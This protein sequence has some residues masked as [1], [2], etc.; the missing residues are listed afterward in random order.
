MDRTAGCSR[1][2]LHE[3]GADGRPPPWRLCW[4]RPS[5]GHLHGG[6]GCVTPSALHGECGEGDEVVRHRE[7]ARSAASDD[8]DG[9]RI[10]RTWRLNSGAAPGGDQSLP[11]GAWCRSG[12]S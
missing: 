6:A 1:A 3:D 7:K 9:S 10:N 5:L 8:E 11:G 12:G 4:G 2:G